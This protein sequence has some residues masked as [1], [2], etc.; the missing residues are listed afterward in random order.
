MGL[1]MKFYQVNE[2]VMMLL[3]LILEH[4]WPGKLPFTEGRKEVS[5]EGNSSV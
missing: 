4:V 5:R 3:L 1:K 2:T